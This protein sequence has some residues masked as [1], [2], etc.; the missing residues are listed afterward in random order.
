MSSEHGEL[1]AALC[2]S[3]EQKQTEQPD[4]KRLISRLNRIEG[5]VRGIVRMVDADRYCVDILT[6]LAALRAALD[7]VAM[8]LLEN[9]AHGCVA[10]AIL[11]GDG[12]EAI[13]ELMSVVKKLKA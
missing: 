9:H 2:H 6:Q 10:K 12:D 5:Q 11:A 3:S 13:E 1:D 4:K 7:G 8:Q